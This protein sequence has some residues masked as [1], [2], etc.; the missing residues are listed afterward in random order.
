MFPKQKEYWLTLSLLILSLISRALFLEYTDLVDPTESRYAAVAQR[1][2]LDNNWL[3]PKVPMPE[4]LVPYIGKPPLHFWLTA[5]SYKT[6]GVD[7]WTSRLP[8]FFAAVLILLLIYNFGVSY[9]SKEIA[10]SACTIALSCCVFF[11]AAGASIIDV[12]L[13]ALITAAVVNL[14]IFKSKLNHARRYAYLS[15]AFSA[16]GFLCKGPIALV[17]IALP[18]LISSLI[19]KDF[20]WLKRLPWLGCISILICLNAPWF[21]LSEIENPGFLK[22]F[23]W[24]ENIARYILK[25]YGDKFGFGHTHPYGTAWLLMVVVAFPWSIFLGVAGFK[26]RRGSDWSWLTANNEVLFCFCWGISSALFF[27]FVRQLHIMYLLPAVPGLAL[28]TAKILAV[29][30][31]KSHNRMLH[32]WNSFGAYSSLLVS[33][34]LLIFSVYLSDSASIAICLTVVS[35][36]LLIIYK[37]KQFES[38]PNFISS[39]STAF[40]CNYVLALTILTPFINQKNSS[41]EILKQ[42]PIIRAGQASP[43]VGIVSKNSFS[44]YWYSGAWQE[45]LDQKVDIIY[46]PILSIPVAEVD[47]LLAKHRSVPAEALKK[48]R[49]LAQNLDWTL[50]KKAS[51]YNSGF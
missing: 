18:F 27:T 7:E 19:R 47:Y 3:T 42:I 31:N 25:D 37:L 40:I 13:T 50:Y 12:S 45:E 8:S 20:G 46:L 29:F 23:F 33:I 49:V 17:L 16:L 2:L 28:L 44:T 48:Y 34:F 43:R 38:Y 15:A 36:T 35:I 4:G 5:L 10:L 41:E 9:F 26:S 22:Y 51:D 6:L 24:N 14:Y 39:I 21:I 11:I 30:Y 32:Y 1:M